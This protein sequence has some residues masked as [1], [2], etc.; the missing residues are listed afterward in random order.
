M[1]RI[2]HKRVY[3]H[4]FENKLLDEYQGGFL[5]GYSTVHQLLELYK[6]VLGGL[7]KVSKLFRDFCDFSKAF[8]RV[9][10]KGLLH[11]LKTYDWWS[12]RRTKKYL[13]N[14]QQRVVIKIQC[15]RLQCL[16]WNS[17]KIFVRFSVIYHFYKRYTMYLK[18]E[19][20]WQDFFEDNTSYGV[21]SN[22]LVY[23]QSVIDHDLAELES[24]WWRLIRIRWMS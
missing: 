16:I 15:P 22:N 4:L 1:E 21:S 9:W 13:G 11:K 19:F 8:D 24:G 6:S 12:F 17:T 2:I 18:S 23:T 3:N 5:P 14:S 20:H 10:H 7:K